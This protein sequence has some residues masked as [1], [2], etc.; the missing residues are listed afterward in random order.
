MI[1]GGIF[2][3][4][5]TTV[6]IVASVVYHRCSVVE[7]FWRHHASKLHGDVVV[8]RLP[9]EAVMLWQLWRYDWADYLAGKFERPNNA[10]NRPVT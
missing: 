3:A 7:N 9:S 4:M 8:R 10:L 5:I 2:G 1:F 6:V